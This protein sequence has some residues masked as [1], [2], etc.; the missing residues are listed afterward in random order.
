MKSIDLSYIIG[1]NLPAP[2][3]KLSNYEAKTRCQVHWTSMAWVGAWSQ[4]L[5]IALY[6]KGADV[7]EIGTSWLGSLIEMQALRPF[8]SFEIRRLGGAESFATS[9]W[10][11]CYLPDDNRIMAIPW[12]LDIPLLVYRRDLLQKAG[13]DEKAAFSTPEQFIDT[14]ERVK[15]TGLEYPLAISLESNRVVHA[16]ASWIWSS[17]GHIRTPDAKKMALR[18]PQAM[19]GIRAYFDLHRFA[20]PQPGDFIENR[21]AQGQVA[22][23]LSSDQNYMGLKTGRF[24]S[25]P[26][27][28]ENMAVAKPLS[29]PYVGGSNL[30]IWRHTALDR[31]SLELVQYLTD[32]EVLEQV[33]NQLNILPARLSLL[34][35]LPVAS[36]PAYPVILDTLHSGRGILGYYR[37]AGIEDRMVHMISGMWQEIFANPDLDLDNVLPVRINELSDRLERTILASWK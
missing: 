8:N 7:S 6:Q 17:G 32:F 9:S 33:F 10:Q 23:T 14:L 27:V 18:E 37:W 29:S 15:G 24:Q 20:H 26:E 21:F 34:E 4:L 11:T 16:L 28:R 1:S 2:V 12:Y 36:D 25:L 19:K 30:V 3:F 13:V 22:I 35:R 31:D 5:S